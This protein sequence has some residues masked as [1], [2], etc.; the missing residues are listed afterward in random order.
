M[1]VGWS[2][3]SVYKHSFGSYGQSRMLPVLS[4]GKTTVNMAEDWRTHTHT[5]TH[6]HTRAGSGVT[7]TDGKRLQ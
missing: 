3:G 6:T 2:P 5:L 1:P 4:Q 7:R